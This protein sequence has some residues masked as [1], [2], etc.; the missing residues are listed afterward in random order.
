MIRERIPADRWSHLVGQEVVAEVI[1]DEGNGEEDS[2]LRRISI[3]DKR[4]CEGCPNTRGRCALFR[5]LNVPHNALWSCGQS[6]PSDEAVYPIIFFKK[7]KIREVCMFSDFTFC[8]P[9][10]PLQ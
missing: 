3:G 9:R 1:S 8:L 5:A 6:V 2:S 10:L 7:D 4:H